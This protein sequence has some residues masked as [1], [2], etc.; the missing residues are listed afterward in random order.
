MAYDLIGDV[1]GCLDELTQLLRRLGYGPAPETTR[2]AGRTAIF[3]GDLVNRGPDTPGVLRAVMSMVR[4]GSAI[5]VAGNHDVKLA[6]ALR[7]H[8]VEKPE[9]LDESL[10]QMQD[11]PD[12]FRRQVIEFIDLLPRRLELDEGRLV[13]AHAGLPIE[14]HGAQ[15]SAEADDFAVNG[16]K[17]PDATGQLVRYRWAN[18]YRGAATVVYGHYSSVRTGWLNGTICIDTGCVYGG[19]LTALRYPERELVSVAAGRI[20]YQS[21]RSDEFRAAAAELSMT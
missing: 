3:L 18:D 1:H 21:T 19:S 12:D 13:V 9:V 6:R 17:V 20:Y 15:A 2:P 16:R 11:E 4:D 5:A 8:E 14:Y 7:G 10:L